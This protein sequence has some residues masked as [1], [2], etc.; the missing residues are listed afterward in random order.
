MLPDEYVQ[1]CVT[2]PPYYG[3]R[4][5]GTRHWFG[6]G[7]PDCEHGEVKENGPHHPGQ[8][9]QTKWKTA[10]AAG[11]GQTATTLTCVQCG[12]WYGQLG[13]EPTPEAYV[14]HMVEVFREL[15]R[16]LRA[17]GTFW[18]NI[19]DSA[20]QPMKKAQAAEREFKAKDLLGIPWMLALAL[21]KD[22]WYLR[23]EI[24]WEK[25]NAMPESVIDRPTKAHEQIF[26]LAK[27]RHYFYDADAIRESFRGKN[28]HDQTRGGSYNPP[29]Q[30]P[31]E[32][33]RATHGPNPL[34]RNSRSVWTIFSQPYKG[35]HF[36]VFPPELPARCIRAGTSEKGACPK[37][38]APW[39]RVVERPLEVEEG[40]EPLSV[41]IGWAPTCKCDAGDPVPCLVLD[42][43]MGSGTTGAEALS[44]GRDYL[45]IEVNGDY[46][47]L[48]TQRIQR[49]RN[50][51]DMPKE[52]W[53]DIEEDT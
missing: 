44:L 18:L 7:N 51:T 12:A 1:T 23:Q 20:V 19:G 52:A 14:E 38:R 16:V 33:S 9:E 6:G 21:R 43:F 28:Y 37:C 15:R 41:T 36:A 47:D 32:G 4:D 45:G 5:Y 49:V 42:P 40:D 22:G 39:K 13:L 2:S 8:V 35:A 50:T 29:G 46:R 11:K 24:I 25:P 26:L 31:H 27:S 30:H 17:D 10:Q 48:I 3:L 53:L 34:G